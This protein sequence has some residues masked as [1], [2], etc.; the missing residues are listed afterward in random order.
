M[1]TGEDTQHYMSREGNMPTGGN[2]HLFTNRGG[3]TLLREFAGVL[4]NNPLISHFDAVVGFLRASGY[5]TLRPF[6][7][8]ISH[9]RILIGI[10]VDKY[11]V[12][13]VQQGLLFTGAAE[14][15]LRDYLAFLREDIAQAGYTKAIDDGICQLVADLTTGKVE[16]RAHPSRKI[17]AKI[18]LLYPEAFN[19]YTPGM[20]L[21]G[22]SNLTGNGLGIT[23]A[24]QYEFNVKLSQY[25]DVAY[26]KN[27]FE[28]LWEEAQDCPITAE[29]VQAML[30]TTHLTTAITP[31]EI[32]MKVL[33][34]TFGEQVEDDFTM[35]LPAGVRDL[36]Y[37]RDAVIQG[38]QLLLRHHGV[39][40][41]DVVGLGK[42]VIAT[43]I[44]KRFIEANGRH[45]RVLVIYPPALKGTWKSTFK[46]FGIREN[47]NAQFVSNGSM[48]KLDDP[49]SGYFD[50]EFFDLVIVDEAHGFRNDNT[51]KY[52]LL[53]RICKSACATP[54]LLHRT[55]KSVLLLSAT[56]LNNGPRD[57]LNQLLLFQDGHRSTIDGISDLSLF[58][59]DKLRRYDE[60]MSRRRHNEALDPTDTFIHTTP[61][62]ADDVTAIDRL[63]GELRTQLLDK[64]TIRRTRSNIINDSDYRD[65]LAAQGITFPEVCPPVAMTYQMSPATTHRFYHT[66]SVLTN[67]TAIEHLT[68]ARYRAVEYLLPEY[69]DRYPKNIG[70]ILKGLF[71]THMVKR[72]ES[73]FYALRKSIERLLRYTNNMLEMFAADR[74][75]I[76]P[77]MNVND[78]LENG[79]EFDDILSKAVEKG[80]REE[81]IV[82]PASA[83]QP[84]FI[85]MLKSDQRVLTHLT[86]MWSE[87]TDD[88]KFATFA[89]AMHD[90]FFVDNPQG[91]LVIFSES[92]DTLDYLYKQLTETLHRDDVL[93]VNSLNRKR[94]EN[95]LRA[96]FDANYGEPADRYNILLSSDVLAEGI[97][98]HRANVI[99]NYD[100]PWNATR[101]MQRIGRVN[102]I[103]T[104][105]QRIHNF[106]FYPSR[107]G[108][109]MIRLYQTAVNKLQGFHSAYGEDTQIFSHEEIVRQFEMYNS[110]V[111]DEVDERMQY[112]REVRQLFSDNKQRYLR[113]KHLPLKS[114]VARSNDTQR[115]RTIVFLQSPIKTEFILATPEKTE[116]IDFLLAARLLKAPIAER[117]AHFDNSDSHYAV[118]NRA[119]A[120]YYKSY[121]SSIASTTVN[122]PT[123]NKDEQKA[124][125]FLEDIAR[126]IGD[127]TVCDDCRQLADSINQGRFTQLPKKVNKFLHKHHLAARGNILD[128][129]KRTLITGFIVDLAKVYTPRDSSGGSS[130]AVLTQQ[131]QVIITETFV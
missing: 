122:T 129:S 67:E 25:D 49:E 27:E 42:T 96:N 103:G 115:G 43:M 110:N 91:K 70:Q 4:T 60:I 17:H 62:T 72:L 41:A 35:E 89:A 29:A 119:I 53:Q 98:L 130:A 109:E 108:D 47:V 74:V 2:T 118:V 19:Q 77:E 51:G 92:V 68:Y 31:Y 54:G 105:A 50:K 33:I 5:F 65:D 61:T 14:G 107:E 124:K 16:L 56:P 123:L 22:S 24:S 38:Y 82:Y 20:L 84:E 32:Y 100:T 87:E 15:V 58:F 59:A 30:T 1:P 76:I 97:N 44:A 102:R 114:R 78:L 64:V 23:E 90:T 85:D 127:E 88:P 80:Y 113:I 55:Q 66:L 104:T 81:D 121:P 63:Y 18:Y 112:L 28:Q 34:N 101:L 7:D 79:L 120:L 71:M 99:I 48:A 106:S 117:P 131:P 128:D 37:Q 9:V 57:L 45:T 39:F 95:I 26:A 40:L 94:R 21:T 8:H 75:F 93:E 116:A 126:T 3:N 125:N 69:Q 13:A 46:L 111:K 52:D 11:I 86:A 36:K 12:S 83:F 73:S 6:L 10:D